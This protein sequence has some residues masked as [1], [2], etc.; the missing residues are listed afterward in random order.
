MFVPTMWCRELTGVV[1]ASP[2]LDRDTMPRPLIGLT[3]TSHQK[4]APQ[5][6][7]LFTTSKQGTARARGLVALVLS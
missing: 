3:V 5:W 4:L 2:I 7:C 1:R 6:L